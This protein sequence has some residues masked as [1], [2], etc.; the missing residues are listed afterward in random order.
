MLTSINFN[1]GDIVKVYQRIKEGE[2]TRTQIFKGLVLGVK[3]RGENKTFTVQ[4]KVGS[5]LVERVWPVNS[6]VLEKVEVDE[7]PRKRVRRAKL[8]YLKISRT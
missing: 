7:V 8:N 4:K 3:G 6:P 5:I 2:K 1:T